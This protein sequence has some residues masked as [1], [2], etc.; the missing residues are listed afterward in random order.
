MIMMMMIS[1]SILTRS[2]LC[3]SD[4]E[5]LGDAKPREICLWILAEL[6]TLLSFDDD[7]E[8]AVYGVLCEKLRWGK[9]AAT[10]WGNWVIWSTRR[11]ITFSL[12]HT[13]LPFFSSICLALTFPFP[14]PRQ[15]R[16]MLQWMLM[17]QKLQNVRES[18]FLL[19]QFPSSS[20]VDIRHL[21]TVACDTPQQP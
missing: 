13:L 1:R 8:A 9:K 14:H 6:A 7:T 15:V 5:A 16:N 19:S 18:N 10:R 2:T 17:S 21:E 20:R 11:A 12:S 3:S 4:S